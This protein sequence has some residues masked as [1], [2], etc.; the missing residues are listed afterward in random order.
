MTTLVLALLSHATQAAEFTGGGV[1]GGTDG[2]I[3]SV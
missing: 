3:L 1:V 2:K